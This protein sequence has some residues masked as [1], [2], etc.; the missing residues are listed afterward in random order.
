MTHAEI[1]ERMLE[2]EMHGEE[3]LPLG[4][5][6]AHLLNAKHDRAFDE[7]MIAEVNRARHLYRETYVGYAVPERVVA[8]VQGV[9]FAIA[10][11]DILR[12]R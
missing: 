3:N 2:L 6:A 7:A 9:T 4:E 11:Q 8:F 10:A 5:F 1:R 12:R